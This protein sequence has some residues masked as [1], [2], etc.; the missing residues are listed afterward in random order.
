M[1]ISDKPTADI[2]IKARTDSEWDSCDFALVHISDE[3]KK[4]Q[5][6]RLE[7]VKPFKDDYNFQSMRF[8]SYSAEFYQS[9]GDEMPDVEEL[10]GDKDWSFVELDEDEQDKFTSPEN[11][12]DF[13]KIV[14]HRDGDARY[15]A[16]GKH[17]NEE[18][19]TNEFSLPQL[20]EQTVEV[21]CK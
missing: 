16:F 2:L 9:G 13:Y 15:E 21:D 5:A 1:K 17:T 11:R 19:W 3:W 7:A 12:L 4:L 18:F 10:L 14:I 20:I 6:E 8:Y